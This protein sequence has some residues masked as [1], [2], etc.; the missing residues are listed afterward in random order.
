MTVD[1]ASPPNIKL[2]IDNP[3]TVSGSGTANAETVGTSSPI[4]LGRY[5][6]RTFTKQGDIVLDNTCGSGSFL[7]SAILEGRKFIG[8]EKNEEVYLHKKNKVDYIGICKKRIKEA[9]ARTSNKLF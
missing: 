7:V 9:G 1:N 4:E 2:Y 8:I 5:F 3:T 6:I